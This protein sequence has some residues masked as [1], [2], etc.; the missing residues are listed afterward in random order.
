MDDDEV[1]A[2]DRRWAGNGDCFKKDVTEDT[3]ENDKKT[4]I[5]DSIASHDKS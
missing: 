5:S 4:I 3:F 1:I 2:A